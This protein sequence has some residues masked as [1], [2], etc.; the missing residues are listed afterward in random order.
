ML[1]R[2]S[3]PSNYTYILYTTT[4]RCCLP[5]SAGDPPVLALFAAAAATAAAVADTVSMLERFRLL[6]PSDEG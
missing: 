4:C 6:F 3:G 2:M 1:M 5:M